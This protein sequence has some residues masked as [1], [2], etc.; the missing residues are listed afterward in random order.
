[1]LQA[2]QLQGRCITLSLQL[3]LE[4]SQLRPHLLLLF[5]NVSH[6]E[7]AAFAV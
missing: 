2:L 7:H 6:P 3:P 4:L 1:M 5:A